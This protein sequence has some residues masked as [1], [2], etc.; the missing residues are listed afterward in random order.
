[1]K[2]HFKPPASERVKF[3]I[4]EANSPNKRV[5]TAKVIGAV[6]LV[7]SLPLV[8]VGFGVFAIFSFLAGLAIF[9]LARFLE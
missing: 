3:G 1:M 5:R 4:P 7:V 8:L 6:L 2:A 9:V